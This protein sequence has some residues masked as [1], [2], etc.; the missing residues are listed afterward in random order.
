M[1]DT[2]DRGSIIVTRSVQPSESHWERRRK[3]PIVKFIDY[4]CPTRRDEETEK[5][6]NDGRVI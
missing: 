3:N 2:P 6:K 5:E 1:L 4:E